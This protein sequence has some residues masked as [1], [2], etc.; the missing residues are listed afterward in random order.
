GIIGEK[1][2]GM[3]MVSFG[4]Q[5]EFPHSPDE[6]VRIDTVAPFFRVLCGTLERLG[7]P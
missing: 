7:T 3:D 6:R 5:I 4:P 2:P 1:Y